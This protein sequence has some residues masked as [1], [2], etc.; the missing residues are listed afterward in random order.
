MKIKVLIRC[1]LLA[2]LIGQS[3]CAFTPPPDP[4]AGWHFAR[5]N[6]D[7]TVEKDYQDYIQKLPP[8]ERNGL[9][10]IHYFKDDSGQHAIMIM[11]SI[12]NQVW[13]HILIYDQ[14]EKRIKAI[15][16]VSGNYQS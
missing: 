11:I 1:V 12:N 6:P 2:V 5:Y 8:D 14:N 16:Y 15:K 13:R 7:S 4:L 3:G 9:G 10:P